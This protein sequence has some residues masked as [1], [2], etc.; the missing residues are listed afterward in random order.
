[1]VTSQVI[2]KGL[3]RIPPPSADHIYS[4]GDFVFVYRE[5]LKHY[6]GPH[7]IAEIT[8]KHVR[9]HLGENTGPRSFNISQIRP[10]NFN[11]N[12]EE[13]LP[14]QSL[15]SGRISVLWTELLPIGDPREVYF[16]DAKRQEILGLIERGTFRVVLTEEAV[17]NPN[18]IHPDMSSQSNTQRMVQP[19][20]RLDLLLEAI[21]TKRRLL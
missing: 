1:M 20:T 17:Q 9:I 14:D 10:S 8:G 15:R 7:P 16:D 11:Q 21:V 5:G 4:P 13:H 2:K 19:S 3:R 6:T 18:I 12:V